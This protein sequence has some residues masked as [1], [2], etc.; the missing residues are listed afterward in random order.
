MRVE[1]TEVSTDTRRDTALSAIAWSDLGMDTLDTRGRDRL[2]F[3][4][5]YV[6]AIREALRS[7]YAAGQEAAR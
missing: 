6:G 5:V 1:T 4:E 2:D 7:A 3:R